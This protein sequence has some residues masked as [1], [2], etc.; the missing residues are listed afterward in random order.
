M[1]RPAPQKTAY[2]FYLGH[3]D[4]F[5]E[6]KLYQASCP[7]A[8]IFVEEFG[9][10]FGFEYL[11]GKTGTQRSRRHALVLSGLR[12]LNNDNPKVFLNGLDA[13][14]SVGAGTGKDDADGLFLA[15]FGEGLEKDIYGH[16]NF[17][18]IPF[19]LEDLGLHCADLK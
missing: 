11:I 1:P 13:L 10:F 15:V 12:V 5:T 6:L 16:G 17:V 8:G 7:V 19:S 4:I 18:G 3:A 9:Y 14:D 2:C